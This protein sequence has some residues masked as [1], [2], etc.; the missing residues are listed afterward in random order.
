LLFLLSL[1]KLGLEL[2]DLPLKKAKEVFANRP[3]KALYEKYVT[4]SL[5]PVLQAAARL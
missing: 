5:F 2:I 3:D 4:G 1:S